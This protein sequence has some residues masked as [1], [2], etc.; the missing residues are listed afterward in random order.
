M[1]DDGDELPGLFRSVIEEQILCS[2]RIDRGPG[3]TQILDLLKLIL[4]AR[5]NQV[6]GAIVKRVNLN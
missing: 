2:T 6:D 1:I 5:T 3:A 4:R